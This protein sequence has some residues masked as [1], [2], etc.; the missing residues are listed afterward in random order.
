MNLFNKSKRE[1]CPAVKKILS[2][3]KWTTVLLIAFSLNISANIYSQTTKLSLNVKNQSIKNILY[4]IENQTDFRFIYES[5]KINLDR[6]VSIQVKEQTVETILKQLFENEGITYEI[7]ENNLILINPSQMLRKQA[8]QEPQQAKKKVTGIVKDQNGEPIIG[9]NVVEK[10][11]TNGT[12]TDVDGKFSLEI[13]E[14]GVLA[15]S[16]I[17]YT[18]RELT[19]GNQ[20]TLN[21]QLR[22]DTEALDE[23][24]VIGYGTV[25]KSDLTGSVSSVKSDELLAV[26]QSMISS[27]LQGRSAGVHVKQNGGA[28]GGDITV[29]IRGTNS[30]L[31]G[32]DPLFVVDGFPTNSTSPALN[33]EDIESIEILKDASAI[34]IYGSRGS[35]GVI[36]ITTKKGKTGKTQVDFSTTV[37]FQ[38]LAKKMD[39]MNAQEYATFYNIRAQNDGVDPY[40]TQDE[41]NAFGKGFDWQDFIFQTAPIRTHSLTV[42]GGSEKTH[43]ALSGNIFDQ[44]GIVGAGGFK[45][46]SVMANIDHEINKHFTINFSSNLA[47]E[48][49]DDKNSSGGRQGGTLMSGALVDPPVLTPYNED[50]SY[51]VFEGA[52][53][54]ITTGGALINP[55][56]ILNEWSKKWKKNR[57]L[58]NLSLTYEPIEGLYIKI[59]GGVENTDRR[60]DTYTSVN[61]YNSVGSASVSTTQVISFL[62]ENTIN[63][64]KTFAD[65]HN[66]SALAGFTYQDYEQTTLGGSGSGF[67]SDLTYTGNLGSASTAGIPSSSYQKWVLL[68]TI[69]RL[70][71]NFDQRYLF[72]FSFRA[73]GSSRY[74]DGDKWGYF[75]SGAF[76]WRLSEEQF[77][78]QFHWL[79]DMKLRASYGIS[80]SQ[81]ISP[82]ATL[83]NLS[84]GNTVFGNGLY[85]TFAPGSTLPGHLKWET[86]AQLDLGLDLGFLHNRLHFTFDYYQKMTRDLLNTIQL[87]SSTGYSSTL[88]NVG[89]IRNRGFEFSVN[90]NVIDNGEF[91][92]VLDGNLSLN[93][94]KVIKLYNGQDILGGWI[95]FMVVS[96]N[97]NLLREG[98]PMGI[99][100]GYLQ[101]GYD[102]NGVE[103]YKDL[104]QD[105]VINEDDKT[106]IGDPNPDFIYGLNSFMS[107]KGF[108][109]SFF[110]QGS[111]GN[112]MLNASSIDNTLYYAYGLNQRRE[113]LYDHWTPDNTDAKYP[114]PTSSLSMRFSNR[115][116]ENGSYL[117]LKNIE[118]AYNLPI[119]KWNI[120]WIQKVRLSV[121]LQNMLT[122]TKYS[123]WDPDVNSQGGGIGQGIDQNPYPVAKSYTFGINVSF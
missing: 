111:Q 119:K 98:E 71:Y 30:I 27:A 75:P 50:G 77:M 15:V 39:M 78:K 123:G 46:Y 56:N 45:R 68:S 17:G 54:F 25:K 112:D 64:V 113:V 4:Q 29:R 12:V 115:F 84:A 107:Y 10:G 89:K 47:R 105:G 85:T 28:P 81:A 23:V 102:E 51:T 108:E 100:Y 118:L 36:L 122:F 16:Y 52:Y 121:S 38:S 55:L 24:V 7:T 11:T 58:A 96:D 120:D 103:Q 86:T 1:F 6:K 60:D 57:V 26:P 49:M 101:D 19:V 116:I 87:P 37:G 31:G 72:T 8:V 117:R 41:I 66:F 34:A 76:A 61:Y 88:G 62:N 2:V 95:D 59:L 99:F 69:A 92:W 82:Y 42:S 90:A 74:S 35:N 65:K 43:F 40:F 13:A 97:C 53:P 80:G 91:Q 20:N 109:F 67:L 22:E 3:M 18:S 79:S 63:Y 104:N 94:S 114:K 14:G 21:I 83:N 9:A 93:R 110:L 33:M 44:D 106:K 48:L 70:N 32:N 73:D 5:G